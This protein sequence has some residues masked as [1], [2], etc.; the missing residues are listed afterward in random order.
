VQHSLGTNFSAVVIPWGGSADRL[1]AILPGGTPTTHMLMG[2]DHVLRSPSVRRPIF[3]RL[4][5]IVFAG[6]FAAPLISGQ[7]L[8]GDLR[9]NWVDA[10]GTPVAQPAETIRL[11]VRSVIV[12]RG[13]PLSS[14]LRDAGILPEADAYYVVYQLNPS[15]TAVDKIP[16][17]TSIKIPALVSDVQLSSPVAKGLLVRLDV[18]AGI[19]AGL[20]DTLAN[21]A[22]DWVRLAEL[23]LPQSVKASVLGIRDSFTAFDIALSTRRVLLSD[24][25]LRQVQRAFEAAKPLLLG[26]LEERTLTAAEAADVSAIDEDL[27]LKSQRVAEG[28]GASGFPQRPRDEVLVRI[29]V[30]GADGKSAKGLRVFWLPP[31]SRNAQ[32]DLGTSPTLT[33]DVMIKVPESKYCFWATSAND[34]TPPAI[35]LPCA[36]PISITWAA[37][38]PIPVEI[39]VQ[40]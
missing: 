27:R 37:S 14:C 18:N 31:L 7:E 26:L 15:V 5:V 33:P 11:K 28:R 16:D 40:R 3:I 4:G 22:V 19:E 2:A 25:T 36:R 8:P 17:G 21:L 29:N 10:Q 6:L 34:N 1:R 30:V 39:Q 9:S 13:R 12:R 20:R 24:G 23:P 32:R 38:E 35:Q